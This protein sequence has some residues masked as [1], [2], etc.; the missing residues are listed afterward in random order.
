MTIRNLEFLFKPKSVALIGASRRPGSVGALIARN[1]FRSGFEGPVMPV[2][3][4]HRAI[5]RV[6][7]Y[8]DVARRESSP[9]L[10]RSGFGALPRWPA[11]GGTH[12]PG[13]EQGPRCVE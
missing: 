9:R 12:Q 3:P 8:A 7:T 2:N 5:E 1:L 4:K 13:A 10:C 6:L 11:E